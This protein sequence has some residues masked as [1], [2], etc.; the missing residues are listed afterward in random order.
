MVFP[1]SITFQL[2]ASSNVE[3][4]NVIL[5]YG[6]D[7]LSCQSSTSRQALELTHGKQVSLSWKLEYDRSGMIPPGAQIWWQWEISDDQGILSQTEKKSVTVQDDRF[8]WRRLDG[9]GI[10]VQWYQGSLSFGQTILQDAENDLQRLS[11]LMDIQ[12]SKKI[13]ITVY[14]STEE[15]RTALVRSADWVGAVTLPDYSSILLG[16]APTDLVVAEYYISH[17]LTHLVVE[18]LTFNC[19]GVE[20]PTWL[21]EGLAENVQGEPGQE[22]IDAVI[23]AIES[24]SLPALRD[25]GSQFSSDADKARLEYI[26]SNLVVK[27]L[28]QTYGS[29]KMRELLMA[30]QS[31]L[32]TD[33]ALQKVYGIDSAGIDREWR[34]SLGFSEAAEIPAKKPTGTPVPTL[35]IWTSVIPPKKT[36]T[37]TPGPIET[38]TISPSVT[39]ASLTSPTPAIV[40]QPGDP[41]YGSPETSQ[42]QCFMGFLIAPTV[43][44]LFLIRKKECVS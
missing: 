31:G 24:Q 14:A 36:G 3:I 29:G 17:E 5:I 4:Q 18:E 40:D 8:E 43:L 2:D 11:R 44:F 39:P 1:R 25:I 7:R 28:L 20:L 41:V 6:I 21:N 15:M 12:L 33:E 13:W 19:M 26:Q 34:K 42:N 38:V 22:D 30:F 9:Q 23:L 10:S 27:Y 16:L 35:A 32:I 37:S